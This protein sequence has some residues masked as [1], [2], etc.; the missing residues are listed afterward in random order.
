MRGQF[1]DNVK[2]VLTGYGF[3][4]CSSE[5]EWKY[6]RTQEFTQPG[7]V[8]IINGQQFE[9]PGQ[10]CEVKHTVFLMGDSYYENMDGSNQVDLITFEFQVY[11]DNEPNGAFSATYDY[12]DIDGFKND[13]QYIINA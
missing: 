11:V 7:Q 8:M 4:D 13:L 1:I 2:E 5:D 10:Q 12:Q 6:T 9:Q 3:S